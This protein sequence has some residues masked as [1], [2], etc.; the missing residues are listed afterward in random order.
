MTA[1]QRHA[2]G[3]FA[4]GRPRY[5][6]WLLPFAV[7]A[8]IALIVALCLFPRGD[9]LAAPS[10]A[11]RL[12]AQYLVLQGDAALLRAEI[13][14]LAALFADERR[15]CRQ[16]AEETIPPQPEPKADE[17]LRIPEEAKRS[18]DV[19]FLEGCWYTVTDMVNA[20]TKAPLVL[21]YCFTAD[22]SGRAAI[23]LQ[24][25]QRCTA[26][27]MASFDGSGKLILDEL[28]DMRCPSGGG[29]YRSRVECTSSGDGQARCYGTQAIG[30]PWK[31]TIKRKSGDGHLDT[32]RSARERARPRR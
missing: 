22:G 9:V 3:G 15:Q 1:S 29:Y 12:E 13:A 7:G 32:E 19:S 26:P 6:Y 21:E 17:A 11:D 16:P 24:D 8:A 4:S 5:Q 25:G 2:A 18:G 20:K 31:A 30:K 10:G 23:I 28:E 14:R 27:V